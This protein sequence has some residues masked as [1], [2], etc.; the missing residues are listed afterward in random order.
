M[1]DD[2]TIDIKKVVESRGGSISDFAAKILS[3]I[4][5]LDYLN[6]FFVRGYE[7]VEFCTEALSYLGVNLEVYGLENIP[8]DG[9]L[10]T[11]ASNHPLGGIDGVSL[12]SI[13]GRHFNSD[14]ILFVN[15]LLMHVKGLAPLCIPVSIIGGQTRNLS[16]LIEGGFKSGR[17]IIIFP[18]RLCSRKTD[19]VIHD[20]PWTK[21]FV[22]KSVE[23]GRSI[24]PVRFVGENSRR[25]YFVANLCKWLK[26]KFNLA[27]CLLPDEMVKSRNRTFK[28]FFGTP[29][30]PSYFDETKTDSEWASEICDKVYS[31]S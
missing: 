27:M 10:Y 8:D 5:R 17:H 29:H 19:G 30:P 6:M 1:N 4:L 26:I 28:I 9:T 25:F 12:G 18:V 14:P 20:L 16:E 11:F 2:C 15:D 22:R 23:S 7:G 13:V 31:M 24:V 21:M 3:R